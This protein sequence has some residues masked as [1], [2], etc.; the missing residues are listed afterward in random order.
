M[1]AEDLRGGRGD[2][3][4]MVVDESTMVIPFEIPKK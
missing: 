2:V 4:R 1:L 3:V